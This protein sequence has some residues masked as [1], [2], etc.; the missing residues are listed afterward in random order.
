MKNTICTTIL[1]NA[2][3]GAHSGVPTDTTFSVLLALEP[4]QKPSKSF[5]NPLAERAPNLAVLSKG[6]TEGFR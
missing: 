5:S 4:D 6:I 1:Y 2:C 3:S